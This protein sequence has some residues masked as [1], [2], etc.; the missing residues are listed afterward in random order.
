MF[1]NLFDEQVDTISR[2]NQF[3]ND[4]ERLNKTNFVDKKNHYQDQRAVLF[5]LTLRYPERYFLYKYGLLDKISLKLELNYKPSP[6][7]DE[8]IVQ[9]Q[10]LCERINAELENDQDL[11]AL[12][13]GRLD[14]KCYRDINHHILTQ[15]FIYAAVNYLPNI[16]SPASANGTVFGI[17][18][19]NI[20]DLVLKKSKVNL[21]GKMINHSQN[22]KENKRVGDFGELF[23]LKYEI[24]TLN[25]KG[26]KNLAD[27]V[28]HVAKTKGDGLG[29]DILSFDD[30]GNKKY[31]EVKT[32]KG[33][34]KSTFFITRNELEKSKLD[35]ENYFLYRV[36]EYDESNDTAKLTIMRGDLSP[37]CISPELFKV[38]LK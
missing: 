7:S 19:V 15:D 11:L 23:V 22:N 31:I 8:N 13:E 2:I 21:E 10:N 28:K 32:T 24:E 14:S 29:Y 25:N 30:D 27:K 6:G 4:F 16:N 18:E 20:V 5:Y 35:Q 37:L 36:Y 12:H 3:K 9:Y 33:D 26:L 17:S 34:E 1:F 38:N